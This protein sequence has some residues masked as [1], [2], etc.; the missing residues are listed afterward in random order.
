MHAAVDKRRPGGFTHVAGNESSI[1]FSLEQA[2]FASATA[3]ITQ[4]GLKMPNAKEILTLL[5]KDKVLKD[6]LKGE[7]FWLADEGIS[8]KGVYSVDDILDN[9]TNPVG[10]NSPPEKLILVQPGPG[11]VWFT[12]AKAD[13]VTKVRFGIISEQQ[14]NSDRARTAIVALPDEPLQRIMRM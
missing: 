9:R 11:H 14:A 12:V 3:K 6:F 5:S 13:R 8:M 4:A 1:Y 7:S 10:V 2:D